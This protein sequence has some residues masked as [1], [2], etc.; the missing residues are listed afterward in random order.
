[1]LLINKWIAIQ[2]MV[3]TILSLSLIT[4]AFYFFIV[5]SIPLTISSDIYRGL[6]QYSLL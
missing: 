1:M 3:Y 5:M 2:N 6:Y 4:T